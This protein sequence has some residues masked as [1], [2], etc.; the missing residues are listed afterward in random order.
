M[1]DLLFPQQLVFWDAKPCRRT[2]SPTF[3]LIFVPSSDIQH[4][5]FLAL[6]IFST[7]RLDI[8]NETEKSYVISSFS[9]D[10]KEICALLRYYAAQNGNVLPAFRNNL[11]V[12]PS[13]VKKSK[14][15]SSW[16]FWPLK[17]ESIDCPETSVKNYHPMLRNISEDSTCHR[18]SLSSFLGH[19]RAVVINGRE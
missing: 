14:N 9:R 1:P 19:L 8:N 7:L 12:P 4:I 2:S 18:T 6:L 16:I 5:C 15:P 3:R 13:R 10:V 17:M 11:S